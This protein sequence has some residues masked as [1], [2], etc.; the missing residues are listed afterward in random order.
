V[1][2]APPGAGIATPAPRLRELLLVLALVLVFLA[3]A[4]AGYVLLLKLAPAVIAFWSYRGRPA[5]LLLPLEAA[6]L[7]LS[8][9]LGLLRAA[10]EKRLVLGMVP[11]EPPWRQRSIFAGLDLFIVAIGAALLLQALLDRPLRAPTAEDLGLAGASPMRFAFLLLMGGYFVPLA[12][13]LLF[14]GVIFRWL[15][16]K[17]GFVLAALLSGALF[18]ALHFG[19]GSDHIWVTSAYGVVF[20]WLYFR[21]GSIWA[22]VFAHRTT[23]TVA[24]TIAWLASSAGG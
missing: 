6:A 18:G 5:I 1:I 3:L 17:L 13:E 8:V 21:T 7:S 4:V 16:E 2:G 22:P 24:L 23:N 19:G 11:L 15:L 20:A 12:E 14:R 10:G 9:W